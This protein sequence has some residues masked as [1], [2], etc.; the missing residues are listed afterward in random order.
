MGLLSA[1]KKLFK[2]TKVT[3]QLETDRTLGQQWQQQAYNKASQDTP[4]LTRWREQSKGWDDWLKGGDYRKGPAGSM[5]GF[6]LWNPAHVQKQ[7]A[8]MANLE[9]V[10]AVGLGGLGGDSSIALGLA[11]QHMADENSQNAG[12]AYE[13][14]VHG[15]DDFFKN[16]NPVY[17][18]AENNKYGSLF[19]QTSQNYGQTWDRW[20]RYKQQ[21]IGQQI[22]GGALSGLSFIPGIGPF[23]GAAGGA[24]NGIGR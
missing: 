3:Q 8:Q 16:A 18:Q 19:G 23:L 4:E 5:L 17:M 12:A 14:A 21:P 6:D 15:Q 1:I 20:G 13:Q 10:G 9:G 11:K 24:I 7:Q 2:P 22:L